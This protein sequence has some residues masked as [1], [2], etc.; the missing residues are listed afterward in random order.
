MTDSK[1]ALRAIRSNASRPRRLIKE[2]RKLSRVCAIL[3]A[4]ISADR[5][6]SMTNIWAGKLPRQSD[7]SRR[8]LAASAFQNLGRLFGLRAIDLFASAAG[9]KLERFRSKFLRPGAERVGAFNATWISESARCFPSIGAAPA[10]LQKVTV[11]KAAIALI[12]SV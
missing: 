9:A 1:A 2:L 8:A 3:K 11:D 5:M 7:R 10:A 4:Q 12:A 6:P